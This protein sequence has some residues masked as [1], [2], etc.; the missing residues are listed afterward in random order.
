MEK[1]TK[2]FKNVALLDIK[3]KNDR[4]GLVNLYISYLLKS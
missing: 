3:Y 4:F 1:S 2:Y